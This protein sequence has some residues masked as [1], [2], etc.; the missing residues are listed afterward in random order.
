MVWSSPLQRSSKK[1][2]KEIYFAFSKI[3]MN[4]NDFWI[5]KQFLEYLKNN[6]KRKETNLHHGLNL[7]GPAWCGCG[8]LPQSWPGPGCSGRPFSW[9]HS[10]VHDEGSAMAIGRA[11]GGG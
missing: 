9:I 4:F 6:W 11:R 8:G 1:D 2:P 3:Y 10:L 5:F 7:A